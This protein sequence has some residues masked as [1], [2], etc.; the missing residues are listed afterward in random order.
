MRVVV[1]MAIQ[2][3]FMD[4]VLSVK[5][6]HFCGS[7]VTESVAFLTLLNLWTTDPL[8]TAVKAVHSPVAPSVYLQAG[9]VVALSLVVQITLWSS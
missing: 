1:K 2:A 5:T 6:E 4:H 8:I 7:L 3:G 9:P